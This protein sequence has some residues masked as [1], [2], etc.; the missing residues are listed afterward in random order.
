MLHWHRY[1]TL[2]NLAWRKVSKEVFNVLLAS[3]EMMITLT[4][5]TMSEL[6]LHCSH[7]HALVFDEVDVDRV[8]IMQ[9]LFIFWMSVLP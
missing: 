1:V 6:N 5:I 7:Q 2:I 8:E 3:A 9:I 4:T